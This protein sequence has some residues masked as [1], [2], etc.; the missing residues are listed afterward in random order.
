MLLA[1]IICLF[2]DAGLNLY[3]SFCFTNAMAWRDL[4]SNQD[5][6]GAPATEVQT[7]KPLFVCFFNYFFS[8]VLGRLCCYTR[9][10]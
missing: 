8:A 1:F 5:Q 7:G 3:H 4:N 10:F 2:L 6:T 9:A